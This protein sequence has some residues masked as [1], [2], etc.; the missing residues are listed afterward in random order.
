MPE[1]RLWQCFI[2]VDTL[3]FYMRLFAS[4]FLFLAALVFVG[5]GNQPQETAVAVSVPDSSA[6][7]SPMVKT[8]TQYMPAKYM[9]SQQQ[10][11]FVYSI[12]RYAAPRPPRASEQN[13]FEARFDT[14]YKRLASAIRIEALHYGSD[15][16]IFFMISRI[17]PSI[18]VKRVATIGRLKYENG[19]NSFEIYE[20]VARTWKLEEPDFSIKSFFLFDKI[21]KGEDVSAYYTKNTGDQNLYI[22]FPDDKVTYDRVARSWTIE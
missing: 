2:T 15:S 21:V 19:G 1:N 6:K 7:D 14:A 10:A 13:K 17:A 3:E 18:K 8:Y 22:E 9:D 11:A 4:S 16:S 5:C 12:S 20:E